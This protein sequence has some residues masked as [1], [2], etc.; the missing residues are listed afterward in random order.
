MDRKPRHLASFERCR[1]RVIE[2]C[3]FRK[4]DEIEKSIDFEFYQS[5]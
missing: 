2:N 3:I 1:K 5:L 4:L